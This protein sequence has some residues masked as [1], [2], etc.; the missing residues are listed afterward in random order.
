MVL[1][2]STFVDSF[3]FFNLFILFNLFYFWL[4]WV[5]VAARRLFSGCGELGLLFAAVCGLLI[6]VASPV[7]KHGL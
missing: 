3:F 1:F 7:V 6:A 5:L 2:L 4:H